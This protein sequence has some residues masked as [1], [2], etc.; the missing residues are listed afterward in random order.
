MKVVRSWPKEVPAGRG[1]V[2]DPLPRF[3]ME[4]YDYRGLVD[5]GDDLVLLEWDIAVSK[6]DLELFVGQAKAEPERVRVAPYKLYAGTGSNELLPQEVWA[7]RR[8]FDVNIK[9]TASFVSAGDLTC[10]LFGLGMVYLPHTILRR[11]AEDCPGHFSDGSFSAWHN[12]HVEAEPPI[13]WDV[14]PVHLHYPIER[15]GQS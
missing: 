7:H 4:T 6:E 5:I 10:H 13:S 15:I 12:V 1:H 8:Y 11:Y 2:V 9:A 14:R 3:V